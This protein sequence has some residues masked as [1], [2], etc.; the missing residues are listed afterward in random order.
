MDKNIIPPLFT[1]VIPT[2]NRALLIDKTINS[3]LTQSYSNYEIIVVDDG[4]TDNTKDVISKYITANFTYVKIQN[5]ERAAARNY[6]TKIAKGSYINWFDSDDIMFPNHLAEAE[7]MIR[8]YNNPEIFALSFQIQ[9]VDGI[10]VK[11]TILPTPVTNSQLFKGNNLAC[12]PVFVRNDVALLFPFNEDR[13]LSGSEDYDLWMR[14][15]VRFPVYCSKII[16]SAVTEHDNRSM[17]L[18]SAENMLGRY[19]LIIKYLQE[20]EVFSK[21]YLKKI[22][23]VKAS[24]AM[25]VALYFALEKKKR[26]SIKYIA[27]SLKNQPSH[28][29]TRQM[30]AV[31]KYLLIN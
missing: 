9:R 11:N 5:S 26:Q 30:M 8:K 24:C 16:T 18:T 7:K 12:N 20:D 21:K 29:F 1:I 15:S 13:N 25:M 27:E 3:I 2:Y 23:L 14:L 31:V 28:F 19:K 17:N 22:Y 6:G 10:I 4:S